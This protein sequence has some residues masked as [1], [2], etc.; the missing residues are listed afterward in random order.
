[1]S[2]SDVSTEEAGRAI[3]VAAKQDKQTLTK[4]RQICSVSSSWTPYCAPEVWRRQRGQF[5]I[6]HNPKKQN[7]AGGWASD[8]GT[9]YTITQPHTHRDTHTHARMIVCDY[10]KQLVSVSLQGRLPHARVQMSKAEE[11]TPPSCPRSLVRRSHRP[12]LDGWCVHVRLRWAKHKRVG[13]ARLCL[14]VWPQVDVVFGHEAL[15]AVKLSCVP[16]RIVLH[17]GDLDTRREKKKSLCQID[18]YIL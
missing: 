13:G 1:M 8:R 7:P 17:V 5:R 4:A 11:K 2:Q 16:V 12:A 6:C 18:F 9:V 15:P 10:V 14:R 3:T